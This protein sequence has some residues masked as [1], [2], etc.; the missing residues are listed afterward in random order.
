MGNFITD[1]FDFMGEAF[2]F[3]TNLLKSMFEAF[4]LD[5]DFGNQVK[6]IGKISKM[7]FDS[8]ALTI[9]KSFKAAHKAA[10]PST[11]VT[12]TSPVDGTSTVTSGHG[13]REHPVYGG[14]KH[15]AGIDFGA[16]TGA[17][18]HN[19]LAAAD[20][21]V[22]FSGVT[23]GYG[24]LLVIGHADG[25]QTRYGHL[26]EAALPKMGEIVV[27]GQPV[28]V[29]GTTGVSTGVHLHFEV[30]DKNGRDVNPTL[31]GK[32]LA[33]CSS[34]EGNAASKE[35]LLTRYHALQA[36]MDASTEMLANHD[37]QKS[38]KL[39]FAKTQQVSIGG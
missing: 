37:S 35:L 18:K 34:I 4:D 31:E 11:S 8:K 38:N 29:M 30:R 28:G 1:A 12:F 39:V 17:D 6:E 23:K 10:H 7:V 25:T 20:G 36:K 14:Q 9:W 22:L 33:T 21:V 19:I 24:N 13:M 15:H 3:A 5:W 26:A 2:S 27:Q 16:P 32:Q